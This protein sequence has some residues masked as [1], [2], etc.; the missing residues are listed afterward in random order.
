MKDYKEMADSVYEAVKEEK[1][2][3]A[4]RA[5]VIRKAVPCCFAFGAVLTAVIVMSGMGRNVNLTTEDYQLP[6]EAPTDISQET[7]EE[8][9]EKTADTD[10][11][12][13]TENRME[14]TNA[15]G[16]ELCGLPTAPAEETASETT[17]EYIQI[18]IIRDADGNE[19]PATVEAEQSHS[20]DRDLISYGIK[21]SDTDKILNALNSTMEY[22]VQKVVE[23]S[24]N[25]IKIVSWT[26]KYANVYIECGMG[27]EIYALEG[28]KVVESGYLGS[29]G[30]TVT[31]ENAEGRIVK[32]CHLSET[33]VS[34][35]DTVI[36]GQVVGLAG[37]SGIISHIGTVYIRR[38]DN[39][40]VT[41]EIVN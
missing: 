12:E 10:F 40:A 34:E 24:E 32:Y 23:D 11:A 29:T 4:K 3:K 39:P 9:T 13:L 20:G 38:I 25:G 17:K 35:G 30:H 7:A 33:K 31:V 16:S 6:N 26:G 28:G 2:K 27:E 22:N 41:S 1:I 18:G 36:D 21:P 14:I 8:K 37:N 5:G 19:Y 15:E